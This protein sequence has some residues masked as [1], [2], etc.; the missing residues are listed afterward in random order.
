MRRR[1]ADQPPPDACGRRS[2]EGDRAKLGKIVEEVLDLVVLRLADGL[3][4]AAA[5]AG[6]C[7]HVPQSDAP[8]GQ[9]SQA[10]FV[11]ERLQL[12]A[13]RLPQQPPELIRRMRV[14]AP[15]SERGV[16]G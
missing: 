10:I 14:I 6:R 13:D 1:L 4:E 12:L 5:A 11:I 2:V 7:D 8:V 15:R 16:A 3:V 9:A